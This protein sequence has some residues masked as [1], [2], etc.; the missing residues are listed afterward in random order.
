MAFKKTVEF[1]R[2][3]DRFIKIAVGLP[4]CFLAPL[5]VWAGIFLIILPVTGIKIYLAQPFIVAKQ[6]LIIGSLW[7]SAAYIAFALIQER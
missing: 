4:G 7:E 1:L 5:M 6:L 3:L 2:I